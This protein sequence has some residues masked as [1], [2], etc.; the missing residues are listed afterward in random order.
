MTGFVLSSCIS[1]IKLCKRQE[2]T[3]DSVKG[4][5]QIFGSNLVIIRL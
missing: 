5:W 3:S 1:I 2:K 4:V